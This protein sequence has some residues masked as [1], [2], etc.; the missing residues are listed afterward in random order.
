MQNN[1]SD[2]NPLVKIV[3]PFLAGLVA[4]FNF[5]CKPSFCLDLFSVLFFGILSSFF[6]KNHIKTQWLNTLRTIL[7]YLILVVFGISYAALRSPSVPESVPE[8]E[9]LYCGTITDL[10]KQK[11]NSLQTIVEISAFSDIDTLV[12]T[13]AWKPVKFRIF[14]VFPKNELTKELFYG[15]KI[16][17]Y[18]KAKKVENRGNP[19]EFD[20]KGYLRN[21]NVFY[22][23]YIGDFRLLDK[24]QA[25]KL[26]YFSQKVRVKLL[27]I[28]KKYQIE[29]DEFA[30]L[31]ALSLGYKDEI[32]PETRE[33][34]SKSGA[35][36]ILAVSGLHVGIIF[37]ILNFLFKFLDKIKKL[38][39]LKPVLIIVFLWFFAFITGL[40]PSV[41]RASLMFSLFSFSKIINRQY[42]IYN[43]IA[44]TAFILLL[45]NPLQ[46]YSVGFQ[47]SFLAVLSIVIFQKGFYRLLFFKNKILDWL[48]SLLTVSVAAQIG[49]MPV[50]LYY[51]HQFPNYFFITNIVVIPLSGIIL[52]LA[53]ALL[54]ASPVPFIAKILAFMLK[55]SLKILIFSVKQIQS[56][57]YSATTGVF[58]DKFQVVLLYFIL[59]AFSVY[60]IRKNKNSL[61]W[62]MAFT[63]VFLADSVFFKPKPPWK[64]IWILNVP[65]ATAIDVFDGDKSFLML[66]NRSFGK[67]GKIKKLLECY[68]QKRKVKD[69]YLAD[70]SAQIIDVPH[71]PQI[72]KIKDFLLIFDKKFFIPQNSGITN[73]KPSEKIKVDYVLLT[74]NIYLKV[75]ELT[76]LVD[77]DT[78]I[79]D[80]SNRPQTLQKWKTECENL[81]IPCYDITIQGA[82]Q[83]LPGRR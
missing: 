59:V 81:N 64:E 63:A 48:W 31:A 20:F 55:F 33:S 22:Q 50:S 7:I 4:G 73:F 32:T 26:L 72:H 11:T 54:A 49:T 53:V 61:L 5:Q 36:H 13:P 44:L 38:M 35:M 66:D 12:D 45:I 25:N 56:L 16:I 39:W 65:R 28:Y 69:N 76:K 46:I 58:I 68:W 74:G 27:E 57:P 3:I 6:L 15:D 78:V 29:G 51:F 77:F 83:I 60:I 43:S 30:V 10:V 14:A 37:L 17:F 9:K 41:M 71:M 62:A 23:A 52:Y 47:L 75:K 79:I 80:A 34:F 42:F 8:D 82:K 18:A 40:S 21:K 1:F 67:P 70:L 2:K 24:N 19:C